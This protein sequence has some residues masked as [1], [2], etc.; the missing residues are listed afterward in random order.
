LTCLD[1]VK[2]ISTPKGEEWHEMLGKIEPIW[3]RC[4]SLEPLE[5]RLYPSPMLSQWAIKEKEERQKRL[6]CPGLSLKRIQIHQ[7]V[8]KEILHMD[9]LLAGFR[10]L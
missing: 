1:R 6:G 7:Y 2:K 8:D 3:P 9:D 5:L 4:R 10:I